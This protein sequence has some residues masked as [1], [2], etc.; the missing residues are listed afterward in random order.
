V[1]GDLT[2]EE[3]LEFMP[4][5][6]TEEIEKAGKGGPDLFERMATLFYE[7]DAEA[8]MVDYAKMNRKFSAVAQSLRLALK[9]TRDEKTGRPLSDFAWVSVDAKS[10]PQTI[11]LRMR[12]EPIVSENT[13]N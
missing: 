11:H 10:D 1:A 4:A 5:V 8:R 3:L 7:S 9:H 12:P 6:A 2:D 13:D